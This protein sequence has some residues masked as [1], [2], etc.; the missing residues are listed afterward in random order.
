MKKLRT[1]LFFSLPT[2][3]HINPTIPVIQ[4]LVRRGNKVVVYTTE[5]YKDKFTHTGAE[6][7]FPP[8]HLD[9]QRV[10]QIARSPLALTEIL[11]DATEKV[12]PLAYEEIEKL[13]PDCIMHDS[14]VLWGKL[15]G[16]KYNIPAVSL[17]TT[18]VMGKEALLAYPDIYIPEFLRII[19]Q[20]IKIISLV[21]K[22]NAILSSQG[23][24]SEGI[25]DLFSN[26]ERLNIVFT[27]RYLQPKGD[28]FHDEYKFVGPAIYERKGENFTIPKGKNPLVYISLGTIYNEDIEFFQICIEAF[29]GK[30]IEVILS[31]GEHI[32]KTRLG[33]IPSNIYV[34]PHVPQLKILEKTD[35]FVTHAGMNSICE[36]IYFGVPMIMFPVIQEQKMNAKRISELGGGVTIDRKNLAPSLLYASV[37]RLL[38]DSAFKDTIYKIKKSFTDAGGYLRAVD[39]IEKLF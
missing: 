37:R 11:L 25:L 13:K 30:N 15:G 8:S 6:L 24:Q 23:I 35:V 38:D 3:G 29:K 32:D 1:I 36:S 21:K 9:I 14:L 16:K 33:E 20:P 5:K 10:K 34:Y 28:M 22:Y 2:H 31:I 17:I 12:L 7:R 39:E 27:S 19:M 4:E 26:K 18:F